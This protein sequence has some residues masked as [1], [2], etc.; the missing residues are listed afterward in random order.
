MIN[1]KKH[2]Q[3]QSA[4]A[5]PLGRFGGVLIL[6]F[7]IGVVINNIT[8]QTTIHT[9][10][11]ESRLAQGNFYKVRITE[12]GIYKITHAEL[13]NRG[14]DPSNVRMFGFGGAML[15]EDFRVPRLANAQRGDLPEI[16]V[17][18]TG[19][20]ILF[21][22][23]GV[24]RWTYSAVFEMFFHDTNPY[25]LH[26]YY[27]ITSD[28]IGEKRR[29]QKRDELIIGSASV[30]DVSQFTDIRVHDQ[31]LHTVT[32]MGRE[33][34]GE[35]FVRGN[36]L[37]IPFYF[38]NLVSTASL[39]VRMNVVNVSTRTLNP[40]GQQTANNPSTFSLDL[41]DS[42][43]TSSARS[44]TVNGNVSARYEM[45]VRLNSP[46][47]TFFPNSSNNQIL[48]LSFAN[49]T[50]A[51]AQGFLNHLTVNAQRH[52][53]MTGSIMPFHNRLNINFSNSVNRYL[54]TTDNPNIIIW[55]VNDI[56][57]TVQ[58]PTTWLDAYTLSFT[59]IANSARSYIAFDPTDLS[60]IPSAEILE[61]VPNQ[62]IH[63]ME[64]VDYLIITHES[65]LPAAERLAQAH[66]DINGLHVGVVTTQQV[67][68]EFS[69]G[70]PDVTAYRWAAKKFFDGRAQAADNRIRYL[71]LLGKGSFDNR[72]L[73]PENGYSYV[74]TFQAHNPLST[75]ESFV[76]D[77]YFGLLTDNSGTS[78]GHNDRMNIGVGRFPVRTLEEANGIVDKTI[79]Y[80]ENNK[81]SWK[82]NLAFLGD[83]GDNNIHMIQADRLANQVINNHPHFIVNKILL[84]A[85]QRNPV[86]NTFPDASRHFQEL[87]QS[88]L[89][90]V[91][92]MGHA[93]V[94]AWGSGLLNI[95]EIRALNN[96][97]L[98]VIASGSCFF[99]RFDMGVVSAGEALLL[100]PTGGAIG[101]LSSTRQVFSSLN[102]LFM[103]NFTD[104][105]FA[106]SDNEP[107]FQSI[108]IALKNAKNLSFGG[109]LGT[110]TLSF[111]YFGC[112]AV[113]LNFPS[114][115]NV[116]TT[117]INGLSIDD[118]ETAVLNALSVANVRGII[119]DRNGA[120]AENFNG[121]VH[122]TVQDKERTIRTLQSRFEFNDR[123]EVVFRGTAHVVNGEFEISFMVPRNIRL[124]YGSG[125][126]VFYAWDESNG[127]EAQGSTTEFIIG[128]MNEDFQGEN[129]PPEATI[130]LNN[131]D[132][133][134]GGQVNSNPI[135]YANIFSPNG[136]NTSTVIPGQEIVLIINNEVQFSLNG[137][138]RNEPGD[139]RRGSIAFPLPEMPIGKHILMF[140]VWDLLGNSTI[141][142]LEFEVIDMPSQPDEQILGVH[143]FPNPVSTEARIHVSYYDREIQQLSLEVFDLQGRRIWSKT[144][145][146]T[147]TISWNLT[148][149][150]GNRIAP[151]M[152]IYR[153]MIQTNSGDHITY[154]N[155]IIVTQ[156]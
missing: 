152:Y 69:S 84:D 3:S 103:Q 78:I 13:E 56:L 98:P 19:E 133:I 112:P 71:L 89:F 139:F 114:Q 101:V 12:S 122:L 135:F 44:L 79:R 126:F 17:F 156:Q 94:I 106:L 62:N 34:F 85:F 149:E 87:L 123:Q 51:T 58:V 41:I 82:N 61:R 110:N 36:S 92:H 2:N 105:F 104:S 100:N 6:C 91:S 109:S 59:D 4:K 129:V 86:N 8:A 81:G 107:Q 15:N 55:D 76:S 153:I 67:Y 47:W 29:V 63:G 150:N 64:Q 46:V 118:D 80:M 9:Y 24:T 151:G 147:A 20:A 73:F 113:R 97:I 30:R 25:S 26:A 116:Q 95:A 60:Q 115:F 72:G 37:D 77:V 143:V 74:R 102:D 10:A 88:G 66:R 132:F 138:F 27:V 154:S 124:N 75:S 68:N 125:R 121:K 96:S 22:G 131:A 146:T 108:G 111:V 65:F 93:S 137:F 45:G 1:E 52:L 134:S 7:F 57:N 31:Q 42:P 120:K 144:Q 54:L 141:E 127:F 28:N 117:E 21:F 23:Q 49:P 50:Q 38:P 136:I 148:D 11:S 32:R 130:Y 5:S 99:S 90:F 40:Q 14:I 119:V 140:R 48:R 33:F 83:H 39:R 70:T 155:R 18:D 35:R 16:P 128:G 142:Y 43:T 145:Y 53:I